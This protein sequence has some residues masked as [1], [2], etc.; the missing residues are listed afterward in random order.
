[1]TRRGHSSGGGRSGAASTGD[2]VLDN[3]TRQNLL[4]QIREMP[5]VRTEVVSLGRQL[6]N[7]P[8]YPSDEAI[9]KIANMMAD[10]EP[11]WMD[12]LD[13]G[14]AEGNETA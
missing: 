5:E 11:G 13:A 3:I 14:E 7:D 9:D 1:V 12:A 2:A 4:D 6:A 10:L 8:G